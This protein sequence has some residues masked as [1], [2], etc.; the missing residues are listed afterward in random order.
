MYIERTIEEI[1]SIVKSDVEIEAVEAM[2]WVNGR[3]GFRLLNGIL[4]TSK[5]K[6]EK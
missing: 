3:V 6:I 4:F 2:E 5:R 1:L